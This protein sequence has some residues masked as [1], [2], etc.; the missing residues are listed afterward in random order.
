MNLM[1]RVPIHR[2]N[3]GQHRA[4]HRRTELYLL[5]LLGTSDCTP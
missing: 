5:I 1:I 4:A 3:G 2:G